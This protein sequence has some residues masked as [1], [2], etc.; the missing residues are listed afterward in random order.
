MQIWDYYWLTGTKE[1][2][3]NMLGQMGAQGWELVS[4]V[5][6]NGYIWPGENGSFAVEEYTAWLKRPKYL[7][8]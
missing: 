5:P 8:E 7:S 3:I 6:T 4:V 2:I 1:Q